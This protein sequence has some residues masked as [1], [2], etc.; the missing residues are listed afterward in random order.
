M[1]K[2]SFDIE[3][4]D[5]KIQEIIDRHP[6]D[7]P[8]P[9]E[10]FDDSVEE[11]SGEDLENLEDDNHDLEN[12]SGDDDQ[13]TGEGDEVDDDESEETEVDDDSEEAED[14]ES[15][16]E[17]DEEDTDEEADDQEGEDDTE[18]DLPKSFTE[19]DRDQLKPGEKAVFDLAIKTVKNLQTDYTQKTQKVG[20]AL[21]A[22]DA[23]EDQIDQLVDGYN[24]NPEFVQ[25]QGREIKRDDVVAEAIKNFVLLQTDE[26]YRD[27]LRE[28]LNQGVEPVETNINEDDSDEVKYLKTELAEIK[29]VLNQQAQTQQERDAALEAQRQE[30]AL[31]QEHVLEYE[32]LVNATQDKGY[33]PEDYQ[34]IIDIWKDSDISMLAAEQQYHKAQEAVD[35][36]KNKNTSKVVK[37]KKSAAPVAGK[38]KGKAG[39]QSVKK[40]TEVTDKIKKGEIKDFSD[41]NGDFW[42][43]YLKDK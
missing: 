36:K 18:T 16:E 24:S 30:E 31:Y 12:E 19:L 14:E 9:Q 1:S 15:D 37:S 40:S 2:E 26:A 22:M 21:R 42:D 11:E 23:Y 28:S 13:A 6:G 7:A 20:D 27:N 39:V 5:D 38:G 8:M 10:D 43:K 35:N 32:G 33:D 29:Q 3:S 34:N 4:I 17:T 25:A 41:L